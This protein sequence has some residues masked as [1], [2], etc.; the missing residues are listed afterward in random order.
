MEKIVAV[1]YNLQVVT[2][3]NSQ[4]KQYKSEIAV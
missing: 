1:Y 4:N 2:F 3:C